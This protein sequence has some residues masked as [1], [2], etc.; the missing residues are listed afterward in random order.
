M[1]EPRPP[2]GRSIP[3]FRSSGGVDWYWQDDDTGPGAKAIAVQ[4]ITPILEQNQAMAS[5]NDGYSPSRE[6]RRVA[7]IP[8]SVRLLWLNTEG[9][10]CFS[11]DPDCQKKLAAKLDDPEWHYLRTA[12]G[13]V[14]DHW[15]HHI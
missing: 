7:T 6:M 2:G 15:R 5:H 4:E 13:R 14:G 1:A 11:P 9:W 8:A 12:P 3:L 10:D